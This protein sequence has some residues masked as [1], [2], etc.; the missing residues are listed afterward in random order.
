MQATPSPSLGQ[1][2][3]EALTT[4]TQEGGTEVVQAKAGKVGPPPPPPGRAQGGTSLALLTA[5]APC[6][7]ATSSAAHFTM[8]RIRRRLICSGE[9]PESV[10]QGFPGSSGDAAVGRPRLLT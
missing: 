10:L 7:C 6:N 8:Q 2:E 5:V 3:L 9:D 1:V 4:R